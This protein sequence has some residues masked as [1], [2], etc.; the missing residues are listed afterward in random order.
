MAKIHIGL[1]VMGGCY[2]L[3]VN[4]LFR[5]I[6]QNQGGHDFDLTVLWNESLVPRARNS[7]A[8]DFL[9]TDA[10]YLLF[11]DADIEFQADAVD[12]LV[13]RG[14]DIVAA[15]Y[16]VKTPLRQHWA[17]GF[18]EEEAPPAYVAGLM[19]VRWVSGGFT[20][21]RR[22]VFEKLREHTPKYAPFGS[23]KLHHGFFNP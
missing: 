18:F 22:Q 9:A 6:R 11:V 3:M 20:L 16:V 5:L 13:R 12:R 14:C 1:P 23:S 2:P 17:V 4:S 7:L 15:P 19:E 21:I 10:E 8:M